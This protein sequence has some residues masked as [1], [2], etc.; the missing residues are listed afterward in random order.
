MAEP[1]NVLLVTNSTTDGE[2]LLIK[3]AFAQ[4]EEQNLKIRLNLVHVI[5]S[6]PTCYFNIPSMVLLAESYYEEAASALTTIGKALQVPKKNQ[7][8]ITG[9]IKTEVL[10]LA[11]KL[12]THFILASSTSIQD[13]HKSFLFIKNEKNAT[14]I[15]SISSL[16]NI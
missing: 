4:A 2:I 16:V 7:W 11:N 9:R 10:R 5:P 14:P 15:R 13:L 12:H 3:E 1:K 8:V 6:L